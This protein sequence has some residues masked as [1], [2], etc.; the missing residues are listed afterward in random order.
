ML[1]LWLALAF[2][3][4]A[5]A[6]ADLSAI[7]AEPPLDLS[8]LVSGGAFLSS[9]SSADGTFAVRDVAAV[10]SDDVASR[11]AIPFAAI[12]AALQRA[13]V[14]H[15]LV[16]DEDP[17]RRARLRLAL[18]EGGRDGDAEV[19]AF[20]Q[21]ARDQ[22]FDMLLLVEELEDGPIEQ[23]GTNGRWPVTFAT[24]ILLGVGALIPDRTFESR[25]TLRVSL[26][27]LQT[28]RTLHDMLLVPGPVELSL[29]ER[30]DVVGLLL[31]VVVPPFWVG[32]DRDVVIDS[33]RETTER[34]LLL[35]LARDL[36]SAI[37]RRRL[38]DNAPA[39]F[40]VEAAGGGGELL[41]DAAESLTA[42]R[43]VGAGVDD[44]AAFAERL[45]ASRRVD[46]VRFR[47]R[48]RLPDGLR[49]RFQVRV[50]TLRGGVASSTF[51]GV[52]QR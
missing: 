29:T 28:G 8:L 48:A 31:S 49:G 40:R 15:R 44:D 33:L 2:A 21:D 39:T 12:V 18:A 37:V 6:P 22:G 20:L 42:V 27:E 17:Q 41:V 3:G 47:Y 34:R 5:S 51:D 13:R 38:A 26:R 52:P 36:K 35:S 19:E 16:A 14:S 46:G 10:D 45:L 43:L 32:D 30:T 4:C 25:A 24:W 23:Q 9:S 11:E 7:A 1:W 50:G